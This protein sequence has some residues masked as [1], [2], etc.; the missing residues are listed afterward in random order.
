MWN[1]W[2]RRETHRILVGNAEGSRQFGRPKS[3]WS[4]NI[5]ID[6]KEIRVVWGAKIGLMWLRRGY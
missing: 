2:K 6:V 4:T 3:G 1:A 5:Q